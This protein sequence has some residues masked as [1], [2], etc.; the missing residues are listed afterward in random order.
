MSVDVAWLAEAME[1]AGYK[2]NKDLAEAA[3]VSGATVGNALKRGTVRESTAKK[4]QA[5]CG[6]YSIG[7]FIGPEEQGHDRAHS[8]AMPKDQKEE[9]CLERFEGSDCPTS[10]ATCAGCFDLLSTLLSYEEKP[11]NRAAC[12]LQHGWIHQ[13]GRLSYKLSDGRLV[14]SEHFIQHGS[15]ASD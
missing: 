6:E 11:F 1:K 12:R 9:D 5:A 7:P 10:S 13:K 3:G 2:Y 8:V 15:N 4:L 14:G